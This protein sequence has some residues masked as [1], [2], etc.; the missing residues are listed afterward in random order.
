[1]PGFPKPVGSVDIMLEGANGLI[2]RLVAMG[3][4]PDEQAMGARMM[5]G[6]FGVP[7]NS[8]DTLSSTIEFNEDGQILANGQRI[9]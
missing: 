3:F 9:R 7:G 6:L 2:D 8:P 5:L 1:M 4:V